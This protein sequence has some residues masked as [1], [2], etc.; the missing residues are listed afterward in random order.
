MTEHTAPQHAE[1]F[2]DAA[3][4]RAAADLGIWVFLASEILFFGVIFA[5]YTI[6]RFHYP[7]AFA[8]ASKLTNIWLGSINTALLLSS[9][10]C[11]ALAVR[12]AKLG[13][14]KPVMGWLS[15]TMALGLSFLII[16]AVE[17]YLDYTGHLVPGINFAYGGEHADQ[18]K[19]FFFFYFVATG[20][21]AL[22]MLIGI[23]LMAVMLVMAK[24]GRFSKHYFTPIEV[25]GLYW[26]LVDIVWIFLY[27]MLYL[28][29]RT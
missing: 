22:H 4:Q 3:Q 18:V 16:K 27:P 7:A 1:Q 19:L 2:D 11:M 23:V 6:T 28:V 24:R 20:V 14:R 25:S 17:Y 8:A 21:H 29:S 15:L 9:S 12:A 5:A 13:W 10:L 26:H